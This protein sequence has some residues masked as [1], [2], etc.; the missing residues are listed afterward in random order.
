MRHQTIGSRISGW[1][2]LTAALLVV[3]LGTSASRAAEADAAAR[4]TALY[5]A[6]DYTAALPLL[7]EL[8]ASETNGPLLYRLFFCQ[9]QL[10]RPEAR[11]T[12]LRART[13]LE[14]E[15]SGAPG[16]A[17][18]FYLANIY[19]NSGRLSDAVRVA[20]ETTGKIESGALPKPANG[21]QSFQLGK[22][23][24]DQDRSDEATEWYLRA[25]EQ[26]KTE[27]GEPSPT[28]RWAAR[29]VARAAY[30][31]GDF[32]QAAEY[33]A[34]ASVGDATVEDL[35]RWASASVR[36][37]D[38]GAAAQAWF[39]ALR[40]NPATGNRFQYAAQLATQ[41]KA[42]QPIPDSAPD[43]RP[44]TAWSQS[45]LEAIMMEK[46]S[47]AAETLNVAAAVETLERKQKDE[48]QATI[49]D[50]HLNFIAAALEYTLRGYPIRE[51]AF[52]SGYAQMIFH[53]SN[54]SIQHRRNLPKG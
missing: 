30:E 3:G 29:F 44:W 49:D 34:I 15:L 1:A 10:D 12:M 17:T 2:V 27:D 7:E 47:L 38:Y 9:R 24:A 43:G 39:R 48:L 41:A 23:Y 37:M 20:A 42:L 52:R 54:W 26:M 31:A 5:D 51:T 40:V 14:A 45:E 46:T 50:A 28:R 13:A 53:M 33:Y 22:L 4:A 8:A 32:D 21:M 11:Q 16:I 36:R 18:P 25:V 19:R 35:D 6:G